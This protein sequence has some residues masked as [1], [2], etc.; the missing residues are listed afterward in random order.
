M[1]EHNGVTA[2]NM[3]RHLVLGLL[4][5]GPLV[6]ALAAWLGVLLTLRRNRPRPIALAALGIVTINALWACGTFLRYGSKPPPYLPP[7]H[8]PEILNFG[9][10]LLPALVGVGLGFVA[11]RSGAPKWLVWVM[12]IASAPLIVIGFFAVAAV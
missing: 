1:A 7:W 8:D 2:G 5:C 9:F 12:E 6:L 3:T 4:T 10:L 11:A